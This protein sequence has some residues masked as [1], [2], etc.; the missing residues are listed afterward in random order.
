MPFAAAISE[1]PL[2]AHAVGEVTGQVIDVLGDEPPDLAVLLVT[3]RHVGAMGDAGDVLRRLLR[4]R[5]LLGATAVSVLANG[6]EVEETP[7]VTLW[8]GRFG[9]VHPL[10]L[11]TDGAAADPPFTPSALLLLADPFT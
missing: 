6:R 1:H 10:S 3:G 11:A 8:A 7:A 4:P 2:A 9:E 5:T